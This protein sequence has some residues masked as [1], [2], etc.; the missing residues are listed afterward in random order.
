VCDSKHSFDEC[1]LLLTPI[2]PNDPNVKNIGVTIC[3]MAMPPLLYVQWSALKF[4]RPTGPALMLD[5]DVRDAIG[6]W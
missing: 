3:N 1:F 4:N 6:F 2:V 5:K